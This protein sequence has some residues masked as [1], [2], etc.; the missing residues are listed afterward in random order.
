MLSTPEIKERTSTICLFILFKTFPYHKLIYRHLFFHIDCPDW[1]E[2]E[3]EDKVRQRTLKVIFS[4]WPGVL[5][6]ARSKRFIS[7]Y[8]YIFSPR[9]EQCMAD[10][11][12]G[13]P[14]LP[15]LRKCFSLHQLYNEK[16]VDRSF[17]LR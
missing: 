9:L 2:N 7:K 17:N 6:A 14:Q 11:L 1:T 3:H 16:V 4:D 10:D 5:W 13:I 15:C 8:R 12:P